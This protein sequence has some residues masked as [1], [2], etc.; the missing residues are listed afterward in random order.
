MTWF[1]KFPNMM[2]CTNII[3]ILNVNGHGERLPNMVRD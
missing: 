2:S 1:G 3:R